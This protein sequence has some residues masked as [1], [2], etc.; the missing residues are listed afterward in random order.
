MTSP[1]LNLATPIDVAIIG[2]GPSGLAAALALKTAGVDR[3]V[4][5]ERE[6]HAGGIPRSC[7]HLAFGLR[8]FRRL[9]SGPDYSIR[10]VTQANKAG[11]QIHTQTTVTEALPSGVLTVS[12]PDGITQIAPRRVI[13]ATGVRETPR[14][15]RLISGARVQ[16]VLSTG[17]LQSMIYLKQRRPFVRPIV[18]GTELVAFSALMTCQHAGIRPVAMIESEQ[19]ATARWPCALYP[20]LMGVKLLTSTNLLEIKGNEKVE[21]VVVVGPDE[22]RRK[23][24]CDGVILT[25]KFTPESALAR[26]GHLDVDPATGGPVVDQW[27]RCSDPSYFTT[28]NLLRPVETAGR[29]WAEGRQTGQWVAQDLAGDL[30]KPAKSLSIVI[31][32][33]RLKYAMPQ[34]IR[35]N[36]EN[37]GMTN[38]QMRV[39]E[40]VSGT[41]VA[42]TKNGPVWQRALN[43]QPERRVEVPIAEIVSQVVEDSVSFEMNMPAK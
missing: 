24:D 20:R 1:V 2:S 27:G 18:V 40:P 36:G 26:C 7:G 35:Q 43:A 39:T 17:A 30:P 9:L 8:E 19:S 34:L 25:G 4:V 38:I 10:L 11:V 22:H 21:S 29:S 6:Q 5:L 12:S 13:Y 31:R 15:A 16:G 3:I 14:S 41:L 37:G 23:I 33:S 42:R 28:G 32:D